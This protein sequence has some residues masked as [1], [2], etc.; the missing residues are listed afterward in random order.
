MSRTEHIRP[1]ADCFLAESGFIFHLCSASCCYLLSVLRPC[2]DQ[3]SGTTTTT[4]N[5]TVAHS[6]DAAAKVAK[7][8][9]VVHDHGSPASDSPQFREGGTSPVLGPAHV[10]GFHHW[11]IRWMVRIWWRGARR[12]RPSARYN[13]AVMV[14]DPNTGRILSVVNQ[15]LAYP[16]RLRAVL[17][18]QDCRGAGG[19]ERRRHQSGNVRSESRNTMRW[20]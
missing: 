13:G 2:L 11:E 9:G 4:V 20:I 14:A 12:C 18:H 5:I 3:R 10:C 7:V 19:F 6:Y 1:A 17:H 15:K 16:G 8:A